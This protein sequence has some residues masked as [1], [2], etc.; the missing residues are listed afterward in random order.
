MNNLTADISMK[1]FFFHQYLLGD[2]LKHILIR[3][4]FISLIIIIVWLCIILIIIIYIKY[5]KRKQIEK[6]VFNNKL[7]DFA[8]H[9]RI[10][11]S[12]T[13]LSSR[14]FHSINRIVPEIKQK[15]L[16]WSRRKK[17]SSVKDDNN[18]VLNSNKC[19][20]NIETMSKQVWIY[21]YNLSDQDLDVNE[22]WVEN[23]DHHSNL[24]TRRF[25]NHQLFSSTQNLTLTDKRQRHSSLNDTDI[26][27]K[28]LPLVMITDTNLSSTNIVELETFEDKQRIMTNIEKRIK[29]QLKAPYRPRYST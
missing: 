19:Q 8:H 24:P 27:E 7:K 16:F 15:F 14:Q 12:A 4:I 25:S 21:S 17:N 9:T 3:F 10:N 5:R 20:P 18:C 26:I 28:H 1:K 6:F 23:D 13:S 29:R 22:I 2:S 11:S